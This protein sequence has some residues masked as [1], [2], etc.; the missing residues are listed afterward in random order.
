MDLVWGKVMTSIFLT[1]LS[2]W[3]IICIYQVESFILSFRHLNAAT[4]GLGSM[5]STSSKLEGEFNF[6][7]QH[8]QSVYSGR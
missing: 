3:N 2:S 5:M 7:S 1:M 6:I 8:L 4:V